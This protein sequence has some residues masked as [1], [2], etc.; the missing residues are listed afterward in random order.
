M[1]R[2][3]LL[4]LAVFTGISR[5]FAQPSNDE[6]TS[7]VVLTDVTA[8]CSPIAAYTN[9]DATPSQYGPASCF[10]TTQ[11][12]VWFAFTAIATDVTVA[13]RGA[14][15]SAPG[16]TLK[17]PQFAIYFGTCG[18]TVNQLECQQG[19]GTNIAEGYFGGLFVG[20]TYFIR[21][22]GAGGQKGTFQLCV[23]NYNPP[24]EPTSDCPEASILC[25]KSAFVVQK[26]S[27]AGSN[28]LE[29][30]D[31]VCFENGAPGI[32]E[33]NSTWFVWTCSQS[34]TLEFTLSPINL[35]DDLD[36][37]VYRLPNGIGNCNGKQLLRCM[38]SGEGPPYPS[39]CLGP[40][41]L[42]AGDN[43]IS[44]DAGCS[45]PGDDAWLR[46]LDMVQGETYALVVNNFSQTGNGFAIE[47]GGTGQFLGPQADFNTIPDAVCLDVPVVIEDASSFPIGAITGWNWSFG[48][49]A[50]P[51]TATGKGPHTVKFSTPGIHPIVMKL[52]TDLGCRVTDIENVLVYPDVDIDTLVAY[53]DCNGTANG[54]VR[55]DNITSGTPPY[56]FSWNGGAFT[57]R[58]SLT[59]LGISVINLVIRDSNNC[60]SEF[61]IDVHERILTADATVQ[62][63]LCFGDANG[64]ISLNVT[65]GKA[66]VQF[67]WGGGYIPD[68]NKGGFAAGIY[69]V[70][71][72]DDALCR[73]TFN[74]TVTDNPLLTVRIDTVNVTCNGAN[75]GVA[76][77]TPV[78]GVGN[79]TF[80]WSNGQNGL[81]ASGLNP[82]QYLVTITDGN[83]CFTTTGAYITEPPDVGIGLLGITNLR[84]NGI[85][86]GAVQVEGLGG[87]P[88]YTF[89]ADGVNYSAS[90]TLGSLAA[91]DYWILV[92]DSEG[93]EDS[94]Y[95]RV[96]EP[97][98]LQVV[99]IPADTTIDL[100]FT[101]DV[102]TYT[103]PGGRP[104]EF[105]WSPTEG[106]EGADKAEPTITGIR[107]QYYIVR[108][109]DEDGCEAYDTVHVKVSKKRPVYFPNIFK[110]EQAT[111]FGNDYFTGYAGPA[112]RQINFLRVYDRWGSL[113]FERNDFQPNDPYLGWDGTFK[114]EKMYGVFTWYAVVGFLDGR[115]VEFSGD[116]TVLR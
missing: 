23:N 54:E 22:Q 49:D 70:K 109:E 88:P 95:A 18:G 28:N 91:G 100:G 26:V 57:P 7:P 84:C 61:T 68:S 42:R 62:K 20:S 111:Q 46:P 33:S 99:A 51:Q 37:V 97:D 63:P 93:C 115:D 36:F 65:N 86:E 110:P 17:S 104:V 2:L 69:T 112:V 15:A 66:P 34:G 14:T 4:T 106:L 50:T 35:P 64:V 59:G 40:T 31:A 43:D 89:S 75:D 60:Q 32:N 79:Y 19:L 13:V 58:D 73:G 29:M 72:I 53:P 3:L 87:W 10:G 116:V 1:T 41:G 96:T 78:G 24:V 16:G 21:V 52:Q 102:D 30:E 82:G 114:G 81:Q 76:V 101:F 44:E 74:V 107:E 27:G 94:L 90:N 85:P 45:E 8:F 67:D 103:F 38:A 55:I 25:D 12:D 47:F 108:I 39:P 5:A 56:L 6:C 98:A 83:N 48:A 77:A 113:V 105:L 71:A 92:R 11:A 80:L 9:V